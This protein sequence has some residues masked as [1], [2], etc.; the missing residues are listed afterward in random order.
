VV[1]VRH[2]ID[3]PDNLALEGRR[4]LRTGVREDPVAN[5]L[6]QVEGFRNPQR[7]LVVAEAPAE[8][9]LQSRGEGVLTSVPEG[10]MAR[11]VPET[12]RLDEIF[13]QLERSGDTA[14]NRRRLQR[15]GHARSVVI[16]CGIDED[17]RLPL[18]PAKRLGM[19]D[20]IAVALERSPQAAIVLL[21]QPAARVV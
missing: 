17:L 20:A 3:D 4:F 8:A 6:G 9:L 13:V 10:R 7:L 12:D 14:S 15:V 18:Q 21:A 1:D 5:L 11:V 19:Q 2:T 16:A